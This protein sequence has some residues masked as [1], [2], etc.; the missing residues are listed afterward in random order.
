MLTTVRVCAQDFRPLPYLQVPC[1]LKLLLQK[2]DDSKLGFPER[3]QVRMPCPG[4]AGNVS[5]HPS[6]RDAG[7]GL[8][9]E[10]RDRQAVVD[11]RYLGRRHV[12]FSPVSAVRASRASTCMQATRRLTCRHHGCL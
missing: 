10:C 12:R 2:F 1:M 7:V 11:V 5:A 6:N 3:F 9:S 4:F 8:K